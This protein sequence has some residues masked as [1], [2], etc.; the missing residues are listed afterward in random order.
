MQHFTIT[1]EDDG[2]ELTAYIEDAQT[3]MIE[4]EVSGEDASDLFAR[5]RDLGFTGFADNID[6]IAEG[7]EPAQ[8]PTVEQVAWQ[9][10]T[11]ALTAIG[12]GDLDVT[13]PADGN[14]RISL[15][16]GS[17]ID[18]G[19]DGWADGRPWF[20]ASVNTPDELGV[21]APEPGNTLAELIGNCRPFLS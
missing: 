6:D 2:D 10:V 11:D 4:A 8:R 19:F 13:M 18:L 14:A 16:N 9:T 7:P 21:G 15:G 20:I 3:H 5:I 17:T 1:I 12:H